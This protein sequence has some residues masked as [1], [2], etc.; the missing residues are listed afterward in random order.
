MHANFSE[1][2]VEAKARICLSVYSF[3]FGF[4][5]PLLFGRVKVFLF[6]K[7]K[8][9][10]HKMTT[11][12]LEG[13]KTHLFICNGS[14]CMNKDGEEITQAIRDEIQRNALDKEIHTTRTR[15]N[16]RCK[17]ACVVIAYPQGN[18]YRV[19]STEH[20]RTLVQ[21]LHHESLH[22]DHVYTLREGTLQRTAQTTAIKGIEKVKEG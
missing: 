4:Y 5:K 7:A 15:C 12:N 14:S 9:G 2:E 13:M 10:R 20:A 6:P 1:G 16:G 11:W 19:P 3:L 21:D 18:W 17:D 22:N 8:E